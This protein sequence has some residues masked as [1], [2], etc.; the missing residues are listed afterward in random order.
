M[1]YKKLPVCGCSRRE[2]L[3]G[4]GVAAAT[5]ALVPGCMNSP[6]SSL[7]SAATT[8]CG[9]N[10]LCIDQSAKQNAALANV[11]GALL[12]DTSNDTIM[13]I[14]QSSADVIALS[15]ICTH[16]GCSMDFNA[17]AQQLTC[18]CHGSVFNEAGQVVQGP[19][20]RSLQTYAASL[21]SAGTTITLT[22]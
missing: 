12:V 10:Q 13:V 9:T 2:L 14:R 20:R 5:V 17:G 18:P 8:S 7:P 4:L 22:L 1:Q 19:A 3:Q 15:A 6:G 21:D 11:G 16:A